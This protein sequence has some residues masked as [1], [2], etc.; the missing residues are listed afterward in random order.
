MMKIYKNSIYFFHLKI[1]AQAI[2]IIKAYN[3]RLA[4]L[5]YY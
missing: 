5:V 1:K 2:S 4:V 3:A